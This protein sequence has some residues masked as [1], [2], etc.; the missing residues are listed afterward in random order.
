MEAA[1]QRLLSLFHF[2]L[3]D[4]RSLAIRARSI[5]LRISCIVV[6]PF[7]LCCEPWSLSGVW[8]VLLGFSHVVEY[9]HGLEGCGILQSRVVRPQYTL[10]NC[11]MATEFLNAVRVRPWFF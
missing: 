3:L 6:S 10:N 5:P 7:F 4:N 8:V 1:L 2:G 11:A 9:W